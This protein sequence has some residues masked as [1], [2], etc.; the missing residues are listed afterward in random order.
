[1]ISGIRGRRS[2]FPSEMLRGVFLPSR[3]C[4]VPFSH[5]DAPRYRYRNV[6]ADLSRHKLISTAANFN[7]RKSYNCS[8]RIAFRLRQAPPIVGI[9]NT[10]AARVSFSRHA[11]PDESRGLS[12]KDNYIQKRTYR[13]VDISMSHDSPSKKQSRWRCCDCGMREWPALPSRPPD[14][15]RVPGT[16]LHVTLVNRCYLRVHLQARRSQKSERAMYMLVSSADG[17]KKRGWADQQAWPFGR[18]C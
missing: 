9:L 10:A 7:H 3:C 15:S 16:R 12:A 4:L 11:H 14:A 13:P 2:R 1:M 17:Q 8:L 5:W 18:R 6:A